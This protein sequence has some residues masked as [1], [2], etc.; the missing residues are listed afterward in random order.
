MVTIQKRIREGDMVPASY[1]L[2]YRDPPSRSAICYPIPIHLVVRWWTS[3]W[4]RFVI[5]H[6][7]T[8]REREWDAA[9]E[10]GR[11][12][13]VEEGRMIYERK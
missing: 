4:W 3:F 7:K 2:S 9:F 12:E 1:G 13:G 10:A 6:S 5:P 8:R 11:K